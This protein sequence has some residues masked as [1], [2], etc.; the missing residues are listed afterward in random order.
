MTTQKT[1]INIIQ[2]PTIENWEM[3]E[4]NQEKAYS[5]NLEHCPC[6]GKSIKSSNYFIN[7]IH[8]GDAYPAN[9]KNEYEGAWEMAV[10]SECRKKFPEGYVFKK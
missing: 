8:G 9:D 10:G 4:R 6:C 5:Q 3:F 1:P 2:I 7:S